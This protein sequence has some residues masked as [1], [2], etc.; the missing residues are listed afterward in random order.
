MDQAPEVPTRFEFLCK[1]GIKT[2]T[3]CYDLRGKRYTPGV[4]SL[5]ERKLDIKVVRGIGDRRFQ[6]C[7]PLPLGA[8]VA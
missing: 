6:S 3:G 8:W 2:G 4:A 1:G 5:V 7:T